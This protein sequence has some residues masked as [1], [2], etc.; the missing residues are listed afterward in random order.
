MDLLVSLTGRIADL[1]ALLGDGVTAEELPAAAS[2]LGDAEVVELVESASRLEQ[3]AERVRIAAVGVIAARSTRAAG[4]AGVAQSRGHRST[5][6]LVQEMTGATRAEAARQVRVAESLL[7]T[8]APQM[9]GATAGGVFTAEAETGTSDGDGADRADSPAL[10]G[11]APPWHAPLDRA[12]LTGSLSTA[13]HDAIRRGLGSPPAGQR[14]EG[15]EAGAAGTGASDGAA[16]TGASDGAAATTGAGASSETA[17]TAGTETSA[18]IE[19]R[20]PDPATIQAW[21]TA[22]ENLIIEAGHRTVEDLAKTARAIRDLL[23]PEGA[24]SRYLARFERRSFRMW[25]DREGLHHADL[26][27]DDTSAAWLRSIVDS[28][29]RPRRGGPRF[30]DPE[31]R[32]RAKALVDDPRSNPQLAHDLVIDLLRAGA[33]ATPEQ[34]F[35]TKQAG[36]RLVQVVDVDGTPGTG[37]FEDDP[38]PV[39]VGVAGQQVC[40]SGAVPVTID[41]NGRPLDVGREQRLYTSKQ[42]VA[43]AIRDGGCRWPGCDRP[44]AYCEAHHIDEWQR[45]RGRTDLDRGILLCRFHHMQLHSNRWKITRDRTGP[46]RYGPFL[47]HPPPELSGD[48]NAP[49]PNTA[50]PNVPGPYTAGLHTPG[51]DAPGTDAPGTDTSAPDTLGPG[52]PGPREMPPRLALR[53]AWNQPEPKPPRR[54]FPAAA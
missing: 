28:A 24:E 46:D 39:P 49:G 47:L 8:P 4:Q 43:L 9:V 29:L 51:T 17:V 32:V 16:D 2:A 34:V 26:V 19:S 20:I 42:R 27:C 35:G 33:L 14:Q 15:A 31:E 40:S 22:A 6:A 30:I 13:Q 5:V 38:A 12:L 54:R 37:F 41:R 11:S 53:Y 36:V 48:A 44:P 21:R 1:R 23:D 3:L 18:G 25:T 52:A 7:E 10:P 45:D 50:G